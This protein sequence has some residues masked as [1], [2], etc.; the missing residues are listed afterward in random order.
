[1]QDKPFNI[2]A[3]FFAA[4][5][6][7]ADLPAV[8]RAGEDA[9]L[10]YRQLAQVT[11]ECGAVL[12][13]LERGQP[14]GLLSENRPGW[15][16]TYLAILACGGVVVPIDPQLKEDELTRVFDESGIRK[17]FVSG[18]YLDVAEAARSQV[19]RPIEIISLD[20]LPGGGADGFEAHFAEGPESQAALIFTSGT[21]SKP[22]KVILTHRNIISDIE[23]FI[24]RHPFGPG[25]SFLSVLPL[26]HTFEATCGFMAPLLNGGA[27][28]YVKALN[29]R[30]IF[31]GIQRH[32]ITHFISVPLMYEKLYHGMLNAVKK[33]PAAKRSAFKMSMT[34]TRAIHFLTGI[35]PGKK[36]FRSFRKKAGLESL[37]LMVSGGAPL[38]AEIARSFSMLGFNFVEGYGLTETSPVLT[39]NPAERAKS[40]SVGPPLDNVTIKIDNPNETGVGEVLVQ[41]PMV[42]PGYQD[43]P[44]ET[45]KLLDGGWLHTGDMGRLDDEG[46]LYI[47]GRKKSLIVS[48]A[49]KNIYPE[50]IESA[51][52]VS[53]L[54]LEAMVYGKQVKGGREEVAALVYP[55]FDALSAVLGKEA[56]Q[57]S[58]DEI[59]AAIDPEIRAICGRMA[60]FKRV[61]HITYL[62]EEMEKTSTKKIK[63]YKYA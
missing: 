48:A 21:T 41:G 10:T 18:R 17:L 28:Y 20:T 15:C 34:T 8:G 36:V 62:L 37:R 50:E 52:V 26:H 58:N 40:G 6:K 31:D 46:Y 47:M 56:D 38:P 2:A 60:D 51:L 29:S 54:I 4:A 44:E 45:A 55:D 30:E 25:N 39:V 42:T 13:S 19:K 33:A 9:Y 57:I 24:K 23:G 14:I 63:R 61:K 35:N 1:M 59:K 7:F 43:N 22:K 32:H 3:R 27:V 5:E 11:R 12:G 49:G 53:P 16:K